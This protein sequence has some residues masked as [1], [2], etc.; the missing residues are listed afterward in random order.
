MFRP[1]LLLLALS[2]ALLPFTLAI[3]A[4][5]LEVLGS[6]PLPTTTKTHKTHHTKTH[7]GTHTRTHHTKTHTNTAN[8]CPTS[9]IT[10]PAAL[11]YQCGNIC[12]ERPVAQC[13]ETSAAPCGCAIPVST[14]TVAKA[15]CACGSGGCD[16]VWER[17]VGCAT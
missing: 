7:T 11:P 14:V 1:Q 2:L 12:P 8:S 10:G 3:P 5:P 15:G 9:T 4:A 16:V 6:N 17:G 13:V